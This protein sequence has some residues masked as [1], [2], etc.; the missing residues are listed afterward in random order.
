MF[1]LFIGILALGAAVV[2]LYRKD[3]GNAPSPLATP[4]TRIGLPVSSA[5]KK[6]E[7]AP[8]V[9]G[10]VRFGPLL[11]NK[12]RKAYRVKSLTAVHAIATGFDGGRNPSLAARVM[13][14]NAGNIYLRPPA[15]RKAVGNQARWADDPIHVRTSDINPTTGLPMI[16]GTG[17]VDV[18]GNAYGSGSMFG[19]D[20]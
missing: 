5:P 11:Y 9:S 14:S 8:A 15:V 7:G 1:A 18:G 6:E 2:Y 19:D 16:N 10:P 4:P 12:E 13:I 3:G 20:D 17:G